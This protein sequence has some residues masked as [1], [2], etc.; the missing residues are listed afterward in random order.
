LPAGKRAALVLVLALAATAGVSAHRRDEYLQAARLTVEPARVAFELD[1]TPGISVA[2]T[3]IAAI[4]RDR[5]D[6]FSAGEKRA[7]VDEVAS[8]LRMHLDGQRLPFEVTASSFADPGALRRGEG[9]IRLE[10]SGAL[11]RL[12]AGSHR[13]VFL[14]GYRRDVSVYLANALV[15]MSQRVAIAGQARDADQRELTIDYDLAD[16]ADVPPFWMLG[17]VA[18]FAIVAVFVLRPPRATPLR[19]A[20][21]PYTDRCS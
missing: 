6:R 8:A 19:S 5:D 11:P 10:A 16:A 1:M 20:G 21:T 15:P 13:L 4:D 9:T 2:E 14:N 3:I 17:L 12:A 7:Y 18:G